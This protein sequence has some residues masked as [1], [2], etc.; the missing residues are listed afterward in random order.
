[1]HPMFRTRTG[2]GALYSDNQ[3]RQP[4]VE[5]TPRRSRHPRLAN[6]ARLWAQEEGPE[7]PV[8]FADFHARSRAVAEE[9]LALMG[10]IGAHVSHA[11]RRRE[12]LPSDL[13]HYDGEALG[14]FMV[15]YTLG[16]LDRQGHWLGPAIGSGR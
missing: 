16:L 5:R 14:W 9:M 11:L 1:M 3:Q 10:D 2:T 13:L 6:G 4:R 8:D 7:T 12:P 15:L